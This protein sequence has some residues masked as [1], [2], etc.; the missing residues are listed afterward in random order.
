MDEEKNPKKKR[1]F[2]NVSG[3]RRFLLFFGIYFVL[4]VIILAATA[5]YTSRPSFCPTCHYMEPFYNSWK[6]SS[7]NKIQCVECHFEP[8][9]EGKIKGKLNGLVQIVS[10]VSTSYKKR[11]PWA[12]IPDNTCSREGCH[13]KQSIQDT[14]YETKGILFNHKHHLEELR[15]GKKLKCTSCH[16]QIVQGSHMQVTYATCFNC[17]FHKS[18][19]SEHKFDKLANCTTCH[20]LNR[21]TKEQ[22]SSMKYN[23]NLVVDNKID[24]KSC[25]TD[26]IKGKGE[27]GKDRC[28]QCHFEDNKLDKYSDTEFMHKTHIAKHSMNCMYCHTPIKHKV[29]K[30]DVSS[31]PDCQSCHTGAHMSQVQLYSGSSGFNTES[32][33]SSMFQSG[34]NCKGCHILHETSK[35]NI[36]TS[37][38]QKEACDNCH[39]KGYGNLIKQWENSSIQR[40]A[41]IKS[42]YNTAKNI[43]NSSNHE[44]RKDALIK[45]EEANHNINIVDIGKSVHNIQFA[46]KLLVGSY[47]LMTEALSLIESNRKLPEFKS[48]SEYVP[49]ECYNCH[50]GIQEVNKKIFGKTFSH[51]SHIVKQNIQCTRCHSNDNKHGQLI[52]NESS[53]NACHHNNSKT[54]ESCN[55][56]HP[57]QSQTFN[58][59]LNGKNSP[60][61]MKQGGVN[62]N[63]CHLVSSKIVKPDEKICLKCHEAGYDKMASDWKNDIKNLSGTLNDLLSKISKQSEGQND[64]MEARNLL[65]KINIYRSL[66]VHNYDLISTLLNEKKKALEKYAQ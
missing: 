56:C 7:H 3:Y 61:I 34:I 49:N 63:D 58:G 17:H 33:P 57:V 66:Y 50:G 14:T 59:S 15:R 4:F 2:K 35:N 30:M 1:F 51:N 55:T 60:D 32:S 25:H 27:V 37:K 10:Y 48:S 19:D 46:D 44:K 54:N 16:S 20:D 40:L 23:H 39:G 6:S 11:K 62:C 53:C 31:P 22:L 65:K 9:L 41:I 43:I 13:V 45:L 26:V 52:L 12:D 36:T 47:G 64:V 42:I 5:E 21:K 18:D 24:C 8:G 28:F 38:S 29:E